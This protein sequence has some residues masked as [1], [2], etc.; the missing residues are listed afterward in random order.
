M[1]DNLNIDLKDNMG[2]FNCGKPTGF[3]KDYQALPVK[4]K[5]L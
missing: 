1:A 5:E 2:G 3:V 4:T